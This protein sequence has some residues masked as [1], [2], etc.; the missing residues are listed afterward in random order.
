MKPYA[1]KVIPPEDVF[2]FGKIK[3]AI[4]DLPH[5]NLGRDEKGREIE[6]SCHMLARAVAKF[7]P[8]RV[9]DGFYAN[10]L[11]H[12]WVVTENGHLIDIY[13]MATIGGPILIDGS[14]GAPSRKLYRSAPRSYN[15]EFGKA[16]FVRSARLV[17]KELARTMARLGL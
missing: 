12:S 14:P 10:M 4:E 8:V 9:R 5:V 1:L 2:L 6:L 13:P 11:P 17:K 15:G 7:F 16:W 3:K